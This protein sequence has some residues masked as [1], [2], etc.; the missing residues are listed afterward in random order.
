MLQPVHFPHKKTNTTPDAMLANVAVNVMREDVEWLYGE[1]KAH[2]RVMCLVGGGPSLHEDLPNI[3]SRKK[4]GQEIWALNGTHDFLIG[5][6]IVPDYHVLLDARAENISFVQNPRKDVTYLV[7]AMCHPTIFDAL[8]GHKVVLWFHEMHDKRQDEI[9]G[10]A[11][12]KFP[13]RRFGYVDGG[14]TVGLKSMCVGYWMGYRQMHLYGYDSSFVTGPDGKPIRTTQG[15]AYAQKMNAGDEPVDIHADGRIYWAAPWMASQVS[16]MQ[17]WAPLLTEMGVNITIHGSGLLPWVM[18]RRAELDFLPVEEENR[19]FWMKHWGDPKNRTDGTETV[20]RIATFMPFAKGD[21]V[22]DYGCGDG[23][24]ALGLS[25]MGAHVTGIDFAPNALSEAAAA[26][27]TFRPETLWLLPETKGRAKLGVCRD[28][29]KHIP[30]HRLDDV[31]AGISRTCEQAYFEEDETFLPAIRKAFSHAKVGFGHIQAVNLQRPNMTAV[32]DLTVSPPT[33]DFFSFLLAAENRR[34]LNRFPMYG[35]IDLVIVQGPDRGFRIDDNLPR[36]IEM[37][38]MML[39]NV[40]I[41]GADCL[42]TIKSIRWVQKGETFP[43]SDKV[44]PNDWK[45]DEPSR[46]Y[47]LKVQV[48]NMRRPGTLRAPA[49]AVRY[50]QEKLGPAPFVTFTLRD[51]KHWQARNSNRPAWEHARQMIE[52]TGTRVVW[53]DDS[54]KGGGDFP[55]AMNAAIRMALYECAADNLGV[56]NGP[57]WMAITND[58]VR[59]CI[60]RVAQHD[61]A[62]TSPAYFEHCG[63][64]KGSQPG[65]PNHRLVWEDDT[66]EAIVLA[67]N[68]RNAHGLA[69]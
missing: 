39:H 69:A 3:R 61:N 56:N 58:K 50:V 65:N 42:P 63:L 64:P 11:L 57:M 40:L 47:G 36:D 20:K 32:Y 55:E 5:K 48:E 13:F 52:A 28:V 8:K 15:H 45:A 54:E 44:F 21:M 4:R 2:K 49:W 60:F 33:Y 51:A 18:S 62:T 30:T 23:S 6:G 7:N 14:S 25:E 43:T 53:L 24:V 68:E 59:A 34:L 38:R 17:H 67:F 66:A 46:H 31:L 12:A 1:P 35:G 9:V 37:R 29:L 41:P 22:I 26:K 10:R 16:Q 27:I 19:R